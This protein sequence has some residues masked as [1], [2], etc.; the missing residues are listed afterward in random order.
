MH[1][2]KKM[3]KKIY[4]F[5]LLG[6]NKIKKR[7]MQS[8]QVKNRIQLKFNSIQYLTQVKI[9]NTLERILMSMK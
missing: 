2:E 8:I 6:K 5:N 1:K 3:K 4:Y 7:K 9:E